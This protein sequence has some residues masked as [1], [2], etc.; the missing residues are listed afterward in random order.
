MVVQPNETPILGGKK[1]VSSDPEL[2]LG[3]CC[4]I[5]D[6]QKHSCLLQLNF[7]CFLPSFMLGLVLAWVKLFLAPMGEQS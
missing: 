1:V 5:F 6:D 2:F 4:S 7:C 3:Q